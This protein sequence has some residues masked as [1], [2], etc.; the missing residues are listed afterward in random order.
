[1]MIRFPK[2]SISSGFTLVEIMISI[3]IFGIIVTTVFIS[4]NSVFTSADVVDKGIDIYDMA[5]TCMYRMTLDLR[6]AHISLPPGYAKPEF[7]ADPDAYRMVGEMTDNEMFDFPRL[8]FTSIAHINLQK[9]KQEGIA[10]L[11]Y[12]VR[13]DDNGINQLRRSDSLFPFETFEESGN[14]PILC[15][16]IKSLQFKFYDHEATA[17]DEWD[18]ESDEF[19]YATPSAIEILLEIEQGGNSALFTTM[20]MLPV[21]REGIE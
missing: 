8:R 4:Y 15:E 12:Y 5:A 6:G 2:T 13:E 9:S 20:V 10:R 11:V 7:D 17:H 14:D 21:V 16:Y 1:M 19:R 18:S 3:L